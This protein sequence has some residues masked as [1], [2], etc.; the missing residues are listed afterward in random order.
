[1]VTAA[2]EENSGVMKK[3]LCSG[4]GRSF[5]NVCLALLFCSV[6]LPFAQAKSP[7][8]IIHRTPDMGNDVFLRIWID[9]KEVQAVAYGHDFTG[10]ISPGRHVIGVLSSQNDP[11][12]Q[13][14]KITVNVT[15]GGTYEY[16][17]VLRD[18]HVFL[19]KD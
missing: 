2:R 5:T 18:T 9:G 6:L 4:R 3:Y 16:T 14:A 15:A 11:S 12:H 8:L 17:A 19:E 1:M 10:S 13:P 7:Q